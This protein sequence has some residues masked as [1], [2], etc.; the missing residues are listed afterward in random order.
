MDLV[1]IHYCIIILILFTAY[2]DPPEDKPSPDPPPNNSI[3]LELL[4]ANTYTA[5][6]R[7]AT[8]DT[9]TDWMY[10]LHRNADEIQSVLVF[11]SDTM[12]T[13]SNLTAN[14]EYIYSVFDIQ[15]E[16]SEILYAGAKIEA[17]IDSV[18]PPTFSTSNFWPQGSWVR[19]YYTFFVKYHPNSV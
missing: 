16:L 11:S 5:Q 13:D 6:F 4:S 7:I 10:S 15:H 19:G 1:K 3:N 9:L 17:P 12:F 8:G 2:P 18:Y 14:T